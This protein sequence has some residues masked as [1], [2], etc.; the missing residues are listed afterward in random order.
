MRAYICCARVFAHDRVPYNHPLVRW[1]PLCVVYCH[2][3]RDY[4]YIFMSDMSQHSACIA[5]VK[6]RLVA[7][8]SEPAWGGFIRVASV[9]VRFELNSVHF[10]V[11]QAFA[12]GV[13]IM[14]RALD[15]NNIF[16]STRFVRSMFNCIQINTI[17]FWSNLIIKSTAM[18]M[19]TEHRCWFGVCQKQKSFVMHSTT[20]Y[21]PVCV[22]NTYSTHTCSLS[23]KWYLIDRISYFPNISNV[24]IHLRVSD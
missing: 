12:D 20:R 13:F 22:H 18:P 17:N 10:F 23:Q 14:K 7:R 2:H 15:W 8:Q 19:I 1:G 9:S 11:I 3:H 4:A 24:S 5:C 21:N 16:E 6:M